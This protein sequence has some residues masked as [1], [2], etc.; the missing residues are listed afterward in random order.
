[1]TDYINQNGTFNHGKWQ[2][3]Q[4]LNEDT[5]NEVKPFVDNQLRKKWSYPLGDKDGLVYLATNDK[6]YPTEIVVY[7][8]NRDMFHFMHSQMGKWSNPTQEN[9]PADKLS[10][11]HWVQ[12]YFEEWKEDFDY[13]KGFKENVNEVETNLAGQTKP[14]QPGQ[15]W[16]NDFD[17]VGML[18]YGAQATTDLGIETLQLLFDSFED[19]NYHRESQDLGNALDWMAD[20]QGI[21][22][23][24][25]VEDFMERFR[26]KCMATLDVM[27]IKWSPKG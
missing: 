6:R 8:M 2:R 12:D 26:K 24:E 3:D 4:L 1:M 18:K 9:V 17:Y 16:S 13:E 25:K 20:M 5:I 19:V 11:T 27:G 10:S 23:E 22:D 7:N 15:M 21:E 14:F